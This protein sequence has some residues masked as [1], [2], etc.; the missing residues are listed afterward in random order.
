MKKI[1]LLLVLTLLGT[2]GSLMVPNSA[3]AQSFQAGRIIDD[4][5]FFNGNGMSPTQIQ[6]FLN[7]KV[8]KCDTNHSR[9]SSGNDSGPP[10]TCLKDFKQNTP[11]KGNEPGLC[12]ALSAKSNRTAAQI[13]Y[14]PR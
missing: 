6:Y 11:S 3:H 1:G 8:P 7:S 2:L 4:S 13:I 9:T 12:K 5:V 14:S 10:Y